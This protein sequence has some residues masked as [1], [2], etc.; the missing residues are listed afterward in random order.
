MGRSVGQPVDVRIPLSRPDIGEAERAAVLDVLS[1]E[2]LSL[3]PRLAAFERAIARRAGTRHGVATSSGTAALH[4]AVR[5]LGLGPGDEVV[6]T[7]F[8]FVASANCLVFEG[9]RPVFADVEP[10]TLNL[11]PAAARRAMGARTRAI[12]A[13]DV[14]GHPA[15]WDALRSLADQSG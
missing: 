5:G 6:T 3:G 4:L 9:V 14:F 7:P 2:R 12:L 13:V 15:D 11:D 10:D 1:G 8:S